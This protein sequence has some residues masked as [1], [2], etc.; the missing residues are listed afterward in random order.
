MQQGV[1]PGVEE[2]DPLDGLAIHLTRLGQ[3]LE[4]PDPGGEVVERGQVGDIAPV[5]AEQYLTQ[6][7]QAVDRLLDRCEF[8]GRGPLPMFHLAVVLEE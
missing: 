5:A 7:D 6:V 4:R 2:V 3:P 1:V 8:P